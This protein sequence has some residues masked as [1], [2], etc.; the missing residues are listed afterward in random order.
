MIFTHRK[1]DLLQTAGLDVLYIFC[2]KC[3]IAKM[4]KSV[5]FFNNARRK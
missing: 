3:K 4:I 2:S 1:Y 5:N